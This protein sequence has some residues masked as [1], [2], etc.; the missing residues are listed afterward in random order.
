VSLSGAPAFVHVSQYRWVQY[1][2]G[3]WMN[4][5]WGCALNLHDPGYGTVAGCCERGNES[6]GFV[7]GRRISWAA[8]LLEEDL[9]R[10]VSVCVCQTETVNCSHT[11][12][13]PV[14]Y[15]C[16]QALKFNG[17]VYSLFNDVPLIPSHAVVPLLLFVTFLKSWICH[18]RCA[19][20][21]MLIISANSRHE[22]GCLMGCFTL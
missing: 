2:S 13:F 6:Y 21:V 14:K 8:W 12:W 20:S 3:F 9:S 1:Q 17:T 19:V 10:G 16:L 18:V 11:S 4:S 15:K 7:R 22:F 5:A